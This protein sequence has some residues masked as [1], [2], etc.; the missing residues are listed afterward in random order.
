MN[1]IHKPSHVPLLLLLAA[2]LVPSRVARA[3]HGPGTSGGGSATVSGETLRQGRF[4]LSLRLDYTNFADIS[5]DEAERLALR[6]DEFDTLQESY[7]TTVGVAYGVTDDFQI[8]TQIG[9]YAANDFIDAEVEDGE[10]ESAIA[11]PEGLTDLWLNAK[12]RVMRGRPG[13]LSLVAGIK[14]PTGKDDEELDNGERLEPSSQP[15]TGAVDYQAGIAYSRFITSRVTVDASSVYTLRTEDDDHFEVGDRFDA[16]VAV[17][18]RLTE[19]IQSFPNFGLFG[20]TTLVWLESDEEDGE[21]NPNSGGWTVYLTPGVRVRFNDN[22]ALTVA[23]SIPVYQD[24]NGEQVEADF[25]LAAGLAFT[26]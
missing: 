18:Y 3:N 24:L 9:Y 14:L 1:G 5:R 7:L 21:E 11:D 23:P 16:G 26:F 8:S 13:N 15:G 25:K 20:E 19:S 6:S 17:A 12:Y 22:V 2:V 4:E 10:A